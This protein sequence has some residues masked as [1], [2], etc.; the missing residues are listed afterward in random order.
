MVTVKGTFLKTTMIFFKSKLERAKNVHF[1]LISFFS[2]L[3]RYLQT[4]SIIEKTEKEN[5]NK[6]EHNPGNPNK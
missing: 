4:T 2:L 1:K 3:W 6:T 5:S